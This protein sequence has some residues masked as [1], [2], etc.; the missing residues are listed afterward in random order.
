[1]PPTLGRRTASL[2]TPDTQIMHTLST[3]FVML[4][5]RKAATIGLTQTATVV[6]PPAVLECHLLE[7]WTLF[8]WSIYYAGLRSSPI[9]A[10]FP[11]LVSYRGIVSSHSLL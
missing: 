8:H 2:P 6:S 3:H 7:E 10:V 4:S 9:Q 5:I 11:L 1:M